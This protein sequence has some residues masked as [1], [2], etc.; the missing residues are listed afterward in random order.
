MARLDSFDIITAGFKDEA[1]NRRPQDQSCRTPL[2]RAV[3]HALVGE[4]HGVK[5]FFHWLDLHA[6]RFKAEGSRSRVDDRK[7]PSQAGVNW[8]PRLQLVAG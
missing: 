2:D 4:I 7:A 6:S 1:R 5:L 3:L 8:A